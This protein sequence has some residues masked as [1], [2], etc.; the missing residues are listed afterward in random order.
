MWEQRLTYRD[1]LGMSENF[2]TR[3]FEIHVIRFTLDLYLRRCK[4]L[5]TMHLVHFCHLMSVLLTKVIDRQNNIC[6]AN[7]HQRKSD[8]S[9]IGDYVLSTEFC[10]INILCSTKSV[11]IN[12]KGIPNI[13]KRFLTANKWIL[14]QWAFPGSICS[15]A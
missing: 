11:Q 2:R 3:Y 12:S 15:I 9:N 5:K 10:Q 1:N 14:R 7:V 4:S 8:K 6:W 13:W